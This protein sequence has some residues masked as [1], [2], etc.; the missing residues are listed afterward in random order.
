M[1][2]HAS[3]TFAAC[4]ALAT[5]TATAQAEDLRASLKQGTPEIR[6]A[7]PL[8][9][10]PQGVLFLA[11]PQSAAIFA[12]DTG[13]AEST[14]PAGPVNVEGLGRKIAAALGTVPDQ[15]A[16][17]D[18]AV[19]PA[20][21]TV[22][23]S[24]SRGRGPDAL[25]VLL[26]ISAAG[27][28]E[29]VPLESVR[30]SKVELTNAP[31]DSGEGRRNQRRESIT[32]LA[33]MDGKLVVAGLSNE[34]FASK[35]RAIPFPFSES[36]AGTSVEIFHGAHGQFE[37]RSP[38]RTFVSY[39]IDNQPHLLAAYTCTP[40][41]TFPVSK[42]EEGSKVRGT[43]VAELGNRNRPLDM[44]TYERDGQHYLLLAISR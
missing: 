9:F 39:E 40:L 43:T 8:A 14:P 18:M 11:D 12:I 33:F 19:S 26:T 17:N 2:K 23:L 13:D 3:W 31:A 30:F 4:C 16:I 29:N 24:V 37:T 21:R 22:Y 44:I 1:V 38:V 41:V 15:I 34:E 7:G 36:T 28:I 32:D 27:Q 6:S 5:L 25:P 42:L 10:G 20:S 35:L